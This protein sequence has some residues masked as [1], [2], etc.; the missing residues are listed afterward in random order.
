MY[1][2]LN[3]ALII[4][5]TVM[6]CL[7][8]VIPLPND[9]VLKSYRISLKILAFAYFTLALFNS[10]VVYLDF[11]EQTPD[12]FNFIDLLITSLQSLLFTFTL[13]I[14]FN[15]N[16][17]THWRLIKN[18][19]AIAVFTLIY[20]LFLNIFHDEKLLHIE[21]FTSWIRH[22]TS[23]FRLFFCLFLLG[24]LTYFSILFFRQE[25]K[26]LK[27][28]DNFFSGSS[29]LR[30][31]WVRYTF[32]SALLI[33]LI[34]L[35]T[36]MFPYKLFDLVFS[37]III[38]FYFVFGIKYLNYYKIFKVIEPM[39]IDKPEETFF[40]PKYYRNKQ[41]WNS[42]KQ[43]IID[44][45]LYLKEGVTLEEI[46]QILKTGRTTL[47]VLINSEEKVNF[48]T[49]INVLRIEDSKRLMIENPHYSIMQIAEMTGFSE[50]SNFSRQ[51]KSYT[52]QTPTI[53]RNQKGVFE[54]ID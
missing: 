39:L 31:K 41:V 7:F 9:P 54:K 37:A 3:L 21:N 45:K 16:F 23:A 20:I 30:L 46:A 10:L 44:D 6:G 47:S 24:Q 22:P 19:I 14:L 18:L 38:L 48:R 42:Y 35:A 26:Y 32:L 43:T 51:F 15:P 13:I 2:L 34:S 1:L 17:Y 40:A 8:L 27:D 36:Q 25:K 29:R 4:T 33:G 52:G 50:P 11:A 49:W 5:T 12:Y 28:L 53:W